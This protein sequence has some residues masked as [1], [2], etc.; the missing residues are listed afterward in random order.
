MF[1][2]VLLVLS[3]IFIDDKCLSFS[4]PPGPLLF[5]R[6]TNINPTLACVPSLRPTLW[7]YVSASSGTPLAEPN[8]RRKIRSATLYS[9]VNRPRRTPLKLSYMSAARLCFLS[10]VNPQRYT[11]M[12]S[13]KKKKGGGLQQTTGPACRWTWHTSIVDCI[14]RFYELPKMRVVGLVCKKVVFE[15]GIVG[16]E[17]LWGER[18]NLDIGTGD[19]R[20][21][22]GGGI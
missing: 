4:V 19:W 8:H 20:D 9:V 13:C 7:I 10:H 6:H 22:R 5:A 17:P 18:I 2:P 12:P 11:G 14:V 21:K 15:P 3:F 16:V 1:C